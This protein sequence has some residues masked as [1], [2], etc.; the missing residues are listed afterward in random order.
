MRQAL[1]AVLALFVASV[2]HAE[3]GVTGEVLTIKT[4][5]GTDFDAYAAGPEDATRAVLLLH[6]RYGMSAQVREWADRF[7]E[8]GYRALVIDLYDGRHAKDWKQAT[9]IMTAIDQV[10][11]DAEVAAA[12]KYLKPEQRKV[13]IM[14]WDYGA[15][16]ALLATLHAPESIAAPVVYYPPSLETNQ[17]KL[18]TKVRPVLVVVAERE[19]QIATTHNLALEDGMRKPHVDFNVM[20]VDAERGFVI[21]M[22][23][24]YDAIATQTV[25]YVSQEFLGQYVTGV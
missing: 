20:G 2:A 1:I 11:A 15:T 19:E 9:S 17:D 21:P 10:A 18:Q 23:K 14:G 7:A 8:Q 5:F 13:V 24:Q 16:Q 6:D 25:F 4:A 12:V 22:N 3:Q